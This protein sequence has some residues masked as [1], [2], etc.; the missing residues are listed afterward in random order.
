MTLRTA[1]R[2]TSGRR[3]PLHTVPPTERVLLAPL[4]PLVRHVHHQQLST[5]TVHLH[6]TVA[7]QAVSTVRPVRVLAL[8][9]R[10]V[11]GPAVAGAFPGVV[12]RDPV[13]RAARLLA[14]ERQRA[15]SAPPA[16]RPER[17]GTRGPRSP[18]TRHPGPTRVEIVHRQPTTS[19]ASSPERVGQGPTAVLTSSA[20][21]RTGAGPGG[22]PTTAGVA[23]L[24]AADVPRVVDHVVREIDR[25]LVASRERRG[26]TA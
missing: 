1:I 24:T 11:G 2:R 12:F 18:A 15:G 17:P 7:L 3:R 13:P 14:T 6:V 5:S 22:S 19:F 25:R 21:W 20:S 10:R 8:P 23:P 16:H 26:W 4:R 9:T